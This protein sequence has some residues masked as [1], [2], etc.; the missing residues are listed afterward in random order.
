MEQKGKIHLLGIHNGLTNTNDDYNLAD[1]IV[2]F[3]AG[4]SQQMISSNF[5]PETSNNT[6][7]Q[8]LVPIRN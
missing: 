3:I 2:R 4:F 5:N 6:L 7:P 8:V 1:T